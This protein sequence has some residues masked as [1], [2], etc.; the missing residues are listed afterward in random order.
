MCVDFTNLSQAYPKDYFSLHK[1]DQ[2]VDAIAGFEYLSSLDAYLGY[3]Q[4]PM[5]LE[6]EEKIAFVM[7]IGTFCYRVLPFGL[8][9]AS[10]TY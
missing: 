9:N 3:H 5:D 7:D 2:L 6:D 1:I 4:I 8:K 10:A